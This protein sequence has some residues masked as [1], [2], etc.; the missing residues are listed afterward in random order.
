MPI[1]PQRLCSSRDGWFAY[2]FMVFWL[3]P[4]LIV[5][6]INKPFPYR[7]FTGIGVPY[8][9]SREVLNFANNMYRISCLFPK[10]VGSWGNYYY[11]VLLEG[12]KEW[13]S[14]PEEELSRL[15]PFGYRT[16]LKRMLD[17]A[18]SD[19]TGKLRRQAMAEF[20]RDRYETLHPDTPRVAAVRFMR[21]VYLTGSDTIAKPAGHWQRPPFH[22][23]PTEQLRLVSTHQ[24]KDEGEE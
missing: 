22:T 24:F 8:R 18:R 11:L 16:R 5:G 6:L 19:Q 20:I 17:D 3:V 9:I 12:E 2:L 10:R 7:M 1:L 14:V 13:V 4:I 23:I 21:A 15:K